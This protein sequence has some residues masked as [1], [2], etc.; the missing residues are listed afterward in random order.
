VIVALF[1]C[2]RGI[3]ESK[4]LSHSCDFT[5]GLETIGEDL[6]NDL[7]FLSLH[8]GLEVAE[9]DVLDRSGIS[10][11]KHLFLV[12]IVWFLNQAFVSIFSGFRLLL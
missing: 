6:V 7:G 3:G 11:G 9:E 1:L 5:S 2:L 4:D 12:G 8:S 10:L